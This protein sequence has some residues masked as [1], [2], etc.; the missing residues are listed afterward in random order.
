MEL[1]RLALSVPLLR[2]EHSEAHFCGGRGA[3]APAAVPAHISLPAAA[4]GAVGGSG[5]GAASHL[6]LPSASDGLGS[7]LPGVA[8]GA[9]VELRSKLLQVSN[10]FVAGMVRGRS[11]QGGGSE[12]VVST[13]SCRPQ[14]LW[15][16]WAL[17]CPGIH[18]LLVLL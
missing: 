17:A 4:L 3:F 1:A 7:S 15:T 9:A 12:T 14:P 13:C 8:T 10:A 2:F 5:L 16:D 18:R 11:E 6:Q